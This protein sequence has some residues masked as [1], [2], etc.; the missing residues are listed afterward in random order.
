[1]TEE[2]QFRIDQAIEDAEFMTMVEEMYRNGTYSAE[3]KPSSPDDIYDI[4]F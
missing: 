4:P 2:E 1:M 3:P